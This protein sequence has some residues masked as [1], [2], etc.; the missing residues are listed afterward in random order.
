MLPFV[1]KYFLWLAAVP[2]CVMV[3]LQVA[4]LR[5]ESQTFDEGVHLAAGYRYWRTGDFSMNVEHPPLQKLLSSAPL[6]LLRPPI[7]T[8][9]KLLIDQ[10]EYARA[11][12][13]GGG[14][15]GDRLLFY[16][17]LPTVVL[18][19]LLLVGVAWAAR[20][21]FGAPAALGALWLCALDP[22][23]IA[24]GRYVTTDMISTLLYFL[25]IV[26]WL[27]YWQSPS[28]RGAILASLAEGMAVGAKFSMLLLAVLIPL[29]LLLFLVLTR[30]GW[31][32]AG[33][34]MAVLAGAAVV[35]LA[36]IALLYA[37]EAW[38]V[39][40]G[41]TIHVAPET[42]FST[43]F[44]PSTY[45][46]GL[47][48][49]M[50]HNREGHTAFLLGQVSDQ[51]WWYYFPVVFAVKSP[52]AV[53]LL[54]VMLIGIGLW[55][56]PSLLRAP[57]AGFLWAAFAVAPVAYFAVT[58]NSRINL[59][60]RHLLPIYPFLYVLGM[61][62]FAAL[63]PLRRYLVVAGLFVGLQTVES[64]AVYPE[65]LGFFNAA[66]GG[67]SAGPR[68]LLDSNLDWGQDLKKLMRY[69]DTH[70]GPV[71]LEYFGS[72]EP[73]HYGIHYEY[74]PKTWDKDERERLDCIG[75]ISHT[76]LRDL[77]VRPGSYEWLRQRPQVGTV[78]SSLALFDLR[79]P[80]QQR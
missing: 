73:K 42:F 41:R 12:R 61:A 51:G 47:R 1:E 69:M 55:T 13:F 50:D 29:L 57:A 10:S 39:F 71:C 72:V 25:T 27:N 4:T 20:R 6:I 52:L 16:G 32:A 21:Y 28:R 38:R 56:A 78:G 58:L 9:E 3:I 75:V 37:P 5:L 31:R 49:L 54:T 63:L 43:T 2:V 79:K 7:P 77:Y 30:P 66:V 35:A 80:A 24:H 60:V 33:R 22:N 59:G 14:A 8:D 48:T 34:S 36:T 17:R 70:P 19:A 11:C 74:L 65:Y 67:S 46:T 64:A 26:L 44:P 53:L 62:A 40:Q 45:L 23:L 15:D 68:Y 76:L 18:S